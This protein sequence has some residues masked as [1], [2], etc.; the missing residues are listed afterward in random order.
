M[1]LQKVDPV[2][3]LM[4]CLCI[5][6]F[7]GVKFAHLIEMEMHKLLGSIQNDCACL[8]FKLSIAV[9]NYMCHHGKPASVINSCN[10]THSHSIVASCLCRIEHVFWHTVVLSFSFLSLL[11]TARVCKTCSHCFPILIQLMWAGRWRTISFSSPT[12]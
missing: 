6:D 5:W 2:P 3:I 12:F 1:R 4:P 7:F 11:E 8:P 9:Q 10:P